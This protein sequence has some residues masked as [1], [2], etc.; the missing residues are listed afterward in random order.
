LFFS[1]IISTTS[2][3]F[4]FYFH[5]KSR[6]LSGVLQH[7][8]LLSHCP[9]FFPPLLSPN[10]PPRYGFSVASLRC[11]DQSS[12]LSPPLVTRVSCKQSVVSLGLSTS[13]FSFF[14]SKEAALFSGTRKDLQ[15]EIPALEPLSP[16]IFPFPA[17]EALAV[18][19]MAAFQNVRPFCD[20]RSVD[21]I[22][23]PSPAVSL[24]P[25][26]PR[27]PRFHP[28]LS[29]R[30][31]FPP[32]RVG[33][34]RF[35][36]APFLLKPLIGSARCYPCSL[37]E[38]APVAAVVLFARGSLL[39]SGV[40]LVLHARRPSP[41]SAVDALRR[42]TKVRALPP[43]LAGVGRRLRKVNVLRFPSDRKS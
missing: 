31:S 11:H 30:R 12:P 42:P 39:S 8:I 41:L 38:C 22:L 36:D 10:V 34:A 24:I 16:N 13:A 37:P 2:L 43:D 21:P 19:S 23:D 5:S 9:R 7:V 28:G 40:R 4:S 27:T 15:A 35:R 3:V 17:R 26:K 33:A 6:A 1:L 29:A 20:S 32:T 14:G 25:E 18:I